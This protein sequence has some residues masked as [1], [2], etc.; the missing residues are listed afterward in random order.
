MD[1]DS[2]N[3]TIQY[4]DGAQRDSAGGFFWYDVKG[5]IEKEGA[6]SCTKSNYGLD[7]G[8]CPDR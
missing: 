6:I 4:Q 5:G 3:Y 8:K 7:L 1:L 2:T